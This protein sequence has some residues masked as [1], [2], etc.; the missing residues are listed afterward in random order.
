MAFRTVQYYL[1]FEDELCGVRDVVPVLRRCD[2]LVVRWY[3]G[4]ILVVWYLGDVESERCG[5]KMI[6]L[7]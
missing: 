4:S 5:L 1:G 3:L 6:L 7:R 2:I